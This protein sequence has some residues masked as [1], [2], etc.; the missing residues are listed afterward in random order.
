MQRRH[1]L[2]SAVPI[3]HGF[4]ADTSISHGFVPQNVD[5]PNVSFKPNCDWLEVRIGCA[6]VPKIADSILN[7]VTDIQHLRCD[8]LN[9][10]RPIT[11]PA[12]RLRSDAGVESN[13]MQFL[14]LDHV[15][16]ELLEPDAG[17]SCPVHQVIC[18]TLRRIS[19]HYFSQK[20]LK[21]VL[22]PKPPV[23]Q[24]SA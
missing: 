16:V 17:G 4:L 5:W 11:V 6:I 21:Q 12:V 20:T 8:L 1:F 3:V 18:N 2:A 22:A 19:Y 14:V 13:V 15:V 9:R 10:I 23:G 7:L 24:F